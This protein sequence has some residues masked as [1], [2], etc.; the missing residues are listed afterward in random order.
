MLLEK[1]VR[2]SYSIDVLSLILSSKS[3]PGVPKILIPQLFK[4]PVEPSSPSV[5]SIVHLPWLDSPQKVRALKVK[6]IP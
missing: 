1:L 4:T 3:D 6:L 2:A 5:T